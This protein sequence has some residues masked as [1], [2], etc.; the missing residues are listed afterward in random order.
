GFG[1]PR[2][3]RRVPRLLR[4]RRRVPPRRGPVGRQLSRQPPGD[5]R[6]GLGAR[7]LDRFRGPRRGAAA[8]QG[9]ERQR[10]G[11][12]PPRRLR[13]RRPRLRR[14]RAGGR[15]HAPAR[16]EL[17]LRHGA[18]PLP[19]ARL[20]RRQGLRLRRPAR[21]LA[22]LP[23]R[24]PEARR[25]RHQDPRR[26]GQ[27]AAGQALLRLVG[28]RLLR[29]PGH[30]AVPARRRDRRAE[31]HLPRRRAGG[32]GAHHRRGRDGLRGRAHGLAAHGRQEDRPARRQHG[33]AQPTGPRGADHRRV[34]LPRLRGHQRLRPAG[35]RRH[36]GAGAP[37]AG[38]RDRRDHEEPGGAGALAAELDLPHRGHAGGMARLL[39]RRERQVGRRHQDPRHHAGV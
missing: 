35:P 8:L 30:R 6:G 16:R 4:R 11:G 22:H 13:H 32:A 20:R 37:Q 17:H 26:Q 18:A 23:V 36:P 24:E 15:P 2:L 21:G 28:R 29:A 38:R 33:G 25:E 10:G 14:A 31:R 19:A 5:P 1:S 9:A 3:V 12:Q 7:R 27:G 39:H 34:R